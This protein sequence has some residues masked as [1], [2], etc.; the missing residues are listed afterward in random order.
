MLLGAFLIPHGLAGAVERNE[1]DALRGASMKREIKRELREKRSLRG[2]LE[3]V[4]AAQ[5]CR[6]P[7]AVPVPLLLFL[8]AWAQ[9]SL[10]NTLP[11]LVFLTL[12]FQ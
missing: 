9:Q 3:A 7:Q 5:L 2:A 6:R 11:Y 4:L 8:A 1:A 10:L 12:F